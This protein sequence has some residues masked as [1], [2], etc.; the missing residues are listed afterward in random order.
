MN[1]R[2]FLP[3]WLFLGR[4][5]I[6]MMTFLKTILIVLLIYFAL[7]FLIRLG[8]PFLMRYITKKAGQQFEKFFGDASNMNTQQKQPEGN[9]T[10]EKMPKQ[11]RRS[12]SKVGEYVDFEE[13]E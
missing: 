12:N 2:L 11:N 3:L 5:W 7:K 13:V 4:I 6:T 10:I 9:V 1:I 8:T